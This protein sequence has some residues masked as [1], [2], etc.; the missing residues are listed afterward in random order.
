MTFKN[1]IK[2]LCTNFVQVWK[3]LVY[4]IL[5]LG[6]CVGFLAIFG[7]QYIEF[8]N[9]ASAQVDLPSVLQVGTFYGATFATALTTIVNFVITFFT[10]MFATNIGAGIF[11]CVIVFILFPFL[12]NVG[13]VATSELAYG[14]MSACQKQSFTGTLIKTLRVSIPYSLIRLLYS[15][16]FSIITLLCI[17]GF[18]RFDFSSVELLFPFVFVI[19]VALVCAF[20]QTFNACWVPA[21]VVYNCSVFKAYRI[22]IRATLRKCL[23]IFSTAFV[24]WILTIVLSMVLGMYALI[25][26]LP[27]IAPLF[28]VF[29]MTAFFQSQGM[30]FYVDSQTIFSPKRLE[31]ND[32]IE[33]IKY[34]L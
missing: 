33:D 32:K 4:H 10:I 2:L 24:I 8:I 3:L 34:L 22:G 27:I 21:K 13:K 16:P 23:S 15:I 17:Y 12:L 29:E 19:V 25:V 28:H 18:T 14:Y 1:S 26:I 20:K 6:I 31:E 5:C 11:L 7:G 30:R 9:Q